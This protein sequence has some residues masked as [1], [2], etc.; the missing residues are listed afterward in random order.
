MTLLPL[1]AG[2]L[3]RAPEADILAA[4]Q[5]LRAVALDPNR[6]AIVE[7]YILKKDAAAFEFKNGTLHFFQPVAERVVGA[8]FVGTGVLRVTPPNDIER[9][10]LG[11]FLDGK[12]ELAEPF[13][14]AVL[15]FSDTTFAELERGL[16]FRAAGVP[17][18]AASLLDHFRKTF[19]DD[20]T[21]NVE[22][23]LLAGLACPR[24]G[25]FLAD[26]KGG[27]HGKLLFSLDPFDDEPV[28]LIHYNN[29][30]DYFDRWCS[31]RPAGNSGAVA[32][33]HAVKTDLTTAIEK[34]RKMS[35]EARTEFTAALEGGRLLMLHLAP[36]LRV[37]KATWGPAPGRE[38]KFIQEPKKKDADLWVI[39][40][41]PLAKGPTY[42][43]TLAYEGDEVVHSEGSGNFFVGQRT[44]WYPRLR[45][46]FD[47]LED[48]T[49]FHMR[50]E[51]PK[52]FTLV[53]TGKPVSTR[54]DGK[55]T[56]S[57]WDTV[58]P[59]G[60]VGFNYGKFKP[61]SQKDGDMEIAVYANEGLGD[62]L[63]GLK[64]LLDNNPEAAQAMGI[65]TGG[66]NTTGMTGR[67]LADAVNS[68][69]V[70]TYYFG[71]VP[72][73]TLA[74]TQQPS[75][76]FGQ[77]WPTLVF[78]PYTSFLDGTIQNQL[79]LRSGRSREFLDEV[80]SHEIAHQWWG[81]LVSGKT[82]HDQWLEEGFAQYSAGLYTHRVLGEKKFKEFMAAQRRDILQTQAGDRL[83]PNSAGPIWLGHRLSA[84]KMPWASR[85]MYSKGAYVLHTLRMMLYDYSRSDDTR[86]VRM[87]R[88]FATEYAGKS[89]TTEDFKRI[90]DRH[91]GQDMSWFFNQWVYGTTIP[92]ITVEYTVAAQDKGAV[93]KGTIRQSGVPA[94]YRSWVPVLLRM[95][96]KGAVSG[97]IQALGETTSFQF[98]LPAQ[99]ESVEFNPLDA[100]L[101]ELEVKLL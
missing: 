8:V 6:S 72:F 22:A 94:D 100:L 74:V 50:F 88:D 36:T 65:T 29:A 46:P 4:Y 1:A 38:I 45:T 5:Q 24:E 11:R 52:E 69:H 63:A 44:R 84:E 47:A 96:N 67:M 49:L 93:L 55:T 10:Q 30:L 64:M 21:T 53:A 59:Y 99:P 68:V 28:Q 58:I 90:V 14:D 31:F 66:F 62:E 19:R 33:V 98:P 26:I 37:S 79:G 89:A 27:K 91:F 80:G 57:E 81:H 61:K 85:L 41:E 101:C 16:K 51:T 42:T 9:R 95:P 78:M 82:Y 17:P 48:R 7:N 83:P 39:L 34:S 18:K 23:Q 87:M 70:F 15:L 25:L 20:L 77:S 12:T 73:H 43:L 13:E 56:V 71:P 86:F 75:S 92:H 40:P 76:V 2:D 3:S 32:P 97:K 60:V 35:G 54:A